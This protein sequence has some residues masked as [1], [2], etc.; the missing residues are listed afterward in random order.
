MNKQ[1]NTN[2]LC[3]NCQN[4]FSGLY[5]NNCGQKLI[6][7]RPDL[8]LIFRSFIESILMIDNP[9]I[10]TLKYA[11]TKPGKLSKDYIGG[12]RK[13][14]IQPFQFYLFSLTIYLLAFNYCSEYMF[15]TLTPE[16]VSASEKM[17]QYTLLAQ[18]TMK[19]LL[20]FLSFIFIGIFGLFIYLLFKKRGYNYSESL[21]FTLYAG[22]ATNLFSLLIIF[23]GTYF[24]ILYKIDPFIALV[25]FIYAIINF[26]GYKNIYSII[27]AISCIIIS[28]LVYSIIV[29]LISIIAIIIKNP[30]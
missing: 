11:V 19:E 22:S 17:M 8:N 14:Y 26:M 7:T 9:I 20:K 2:H 13:F 24:N 16:N 12:K 18:N 10:R 23:P 25:Y 6:T 15:E 27:K 5:C 1:E 29:M 3:P 21:I 28:Y 30:T 4:N